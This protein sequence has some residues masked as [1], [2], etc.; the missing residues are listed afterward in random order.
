MSPQGVLL[1]MEL[2]SKDNT[3]QIIITWCEFVIV[4]RESVGEKKILGNN[5]GTKSGWV[6]GGHRTSYSP[7]LL[8]WSKWVDVRLM[9]G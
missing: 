3:E 6:G 9:S 4:E 1:F 2:S 8:V 5:R 7:L